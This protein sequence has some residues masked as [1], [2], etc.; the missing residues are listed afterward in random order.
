MD[1]APDK[2]SVTDTEFITED[3]VSFINLQ[4]WQDSYVHCCGICELKSLVK[5]DVPLR[6]QSGT[7]NELNV[8]RKVDILEEA[9]N[10]LYMNS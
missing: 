7:L 6:W 4:I 2:T 10:C 5:F 8:A 1:A 3:T 9:E